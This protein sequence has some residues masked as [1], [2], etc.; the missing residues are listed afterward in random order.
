ML[1]PF[2]DEAAIKIAAAQAEAESS[3]GHNFRATPVG[4]QWLLVWEV[5]PG[6]KKET[7]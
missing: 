3:G 1:I 2:G 5:K 7:R 6:P 4:N